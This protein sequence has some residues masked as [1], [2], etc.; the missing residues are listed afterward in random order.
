MKSAARLPAKSEKGRAS[1]R[2][3]PFFSAP[4]QTK[5]KVSTPGDKYEREADNA[6]DAV[7][8]K[9]GPMAQGG[10][11]GRRMTPLGQR[12]APDETQSSREKAPDPPKK[13]EEST[14]R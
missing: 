4:V 2:G 10:P 13:E 12:T 3:K 11:I 5:L 14:L 9:R 6:A 7:I 1:A 8:H